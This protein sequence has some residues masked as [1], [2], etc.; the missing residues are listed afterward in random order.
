MWNS[1]EH[2]DEENLRWSYLRAI[3]WGRWPIFVSQIYA[4]MLLLFLPWQAVVVAVVLSNIF[5]A[6]FIRYRHVSIGPASVGALLTRLKWALC[7]IAAIYLLVSGN[8]VN[9]LFALL[10]PFVIFVIGIIPTVQVGKIQK[11]FMAQLGYE[12]STRFAAASSSE[13]FA[14]AAQGRPIPET[15]L[16][17]QRS[18]K[19]V[20]CIRTIESD[21]LKRT[22]SDSEENSVAGL[23]G[24][25]LNMALGDEKIVMR[26]VKL[27]WKES[28]DVVDAF[29]RAQDL[30]ER[31]HN[32]FG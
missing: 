27:E 15:P 18:G 16:R 7:P 19:V 14:D 5:W 2:T 32:R 24:G 17:P 22:L 29:R 26:L 30:W 1:A 31:D 8:T 10:W 25:L 28:S 3:E 6:I 21:L 23:C 9:A 12:S 20:A 11:M 13:P 4:P